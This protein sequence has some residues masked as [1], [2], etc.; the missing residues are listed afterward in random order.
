MNFRGGKGAL[1]RGKR[2]EMENSAKVQGENK[3]LLEHNF[4][5]SVRLIYSRTAE[6]NN[7]RVG[8]MKRLQ[9]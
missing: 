3:G 2:G 8:N 5:S 9:G 7:Q 6:G 1:K 4:S